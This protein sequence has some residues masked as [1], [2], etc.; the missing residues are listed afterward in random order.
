MRVSAILKTIL[1]KILYILEPNTCASKRR[2]ENLNPDDG[3]KK[4][5]E[6]N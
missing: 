3:E 2:L 5:E 1:A 6:T 4:P